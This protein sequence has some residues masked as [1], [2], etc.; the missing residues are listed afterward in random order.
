MMATIVMMALVPILLAAYIVEVM[1]L[2]VLLYKV[3]KFIDRTWLSNDGHDVEVD[4][5]S[6]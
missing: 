2:M 4:V 1:F 3:Y 6:D 5:D